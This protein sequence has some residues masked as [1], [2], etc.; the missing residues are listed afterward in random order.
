[1]NSSNL[2]FLDI[3]TTGL[4]RT[5]DEMTSLVW[6]FRGS[7]HKWIREVDHPDAFLKDWSASEMLCTYNGKCFD[8]PFLCKT[9]DVPRHPYHHDLR[10][11]LA[12]LGIKGGLKPISASQG[13]ESPLGISELDGC[14]AVLLWNLHQ[15]GSK[16]ALDCLLAYNANDV[17]L[18]HSLYGK[19]IEKVSPLPSIPWKYDLL[20]LTE[21]IQ[22]H[23]ISEISQRR[24]TRRVSHTEALVQ[25]LTSEQS[26]NRDG[27]WYGSVIVFTGWML[28]RAGAKMPRPK[29]REIA[30]SV[31]FVWA[32]RV[33]SGC[34][35]L[36]AAQN[37]SDTRKSQAARKLGITIMSP[38]EFWELIES[39][40]SP[41]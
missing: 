10:Y 30:N 5:M 9:F 7:W 27:E 33:I 35:H 22:Q 26:V 12:R 11:S 39:S 3:E 37:A 29:A 34:T 40:K 8:E 23:P 16:H 31:G 28:D 1:M 21:F 15:Q 6:Y 19:F 25:R 32:E 4:S 24:M 18:T 38:L 13:I 17:I 2:L 20:W 41:S 36:V 14:H